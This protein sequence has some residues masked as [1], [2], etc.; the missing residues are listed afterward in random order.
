MG[1][2]IL[3]PDAEDSEF[4]GNKIETVGRKLSLKER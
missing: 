2:K 1:S 4:V 3:T